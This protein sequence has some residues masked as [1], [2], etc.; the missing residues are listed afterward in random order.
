[1]SGDGMLRVGVCSKSLAGQELLK[2]SEEMV[3]HWVPDC[4]SDWLLVTALRLGGEGSSSLQARFRA[5]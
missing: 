4:H 3:N 1:V 5:P 2:G